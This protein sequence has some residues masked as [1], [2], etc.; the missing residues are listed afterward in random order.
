MLAA[1][2][3]KAMAARQVRRHL[4]RAWGGRNPQVSRQC[5][6][7]LRDRASIPL[8]GDDRKP[9]ILRRIKSSGL[10]TCHLPYQPY[11]RVR[12]S[13][14]PACLPGSLNGRDG[15]VVLPPRRHRRRPPIIAVTDAG[16]DLARFVEATGSGLVASPGR[17]DELAAR[18]I[19]HAHFGTARASGSSPWLRRCSDPDGLRV[20]A[21]DRRL[22]ATRCMDTGMR[23]RPCVL[24]GAPGWSAPHVGSSRRRVPGAGPARSPMPRDRP[25]PGV[26]LRTGDGPTEPP[27][28]RR[29][30]E[31]T[32][33]FMAALLHVANQ[34]M[35][36]SAYQRINVEARR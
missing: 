20:F 31:S 30:L 16:S 32:S 14:A 2:S 25:V 6:E 7:A 15:G 10:H 36:P 27:F 26:D 17:P 18:D 3:A 19:D 9:Q 34:T 5:A 11:S 33:S 24:V 35:A 1:R 8:V 21:A 29:S 13:A 12:T 23:R 28:G 22:L 4:R